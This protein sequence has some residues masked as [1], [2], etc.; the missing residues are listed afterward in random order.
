MIKFGTSFVSSFKDHSDAALKALF[1]NFIEPIR[2]GV[3]LSD[4]PGK[5]KPSWEV[6][7]FG[8]TMQQAFRK[9]SEDRNLH[10][11]HIGYRFYQPGNDP[12]YPGQESEGIAHTMRVVEAENEIETHI[13]LRLDETHPSPFTIPMDFD[14]S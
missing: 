7:A 12:D 6:P 10:H 11:Y 14:F 1:D 13:I 5:Y 8:T 9:V 4:L 3:D 2:N